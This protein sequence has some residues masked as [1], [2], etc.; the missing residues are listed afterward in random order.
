MIDDDLFQRMQK[1]VDHG[2]RKHLMNRVLGMVV[3]VAEKQG[4][5]AV[6]A[7]LSGKFKIVVDELER[8]D[9]E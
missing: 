1:S 4:H 7:I 3:D 8:D 6:G 2:F 5:A 9:V